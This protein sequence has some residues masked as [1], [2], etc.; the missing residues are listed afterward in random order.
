MLC[1]IGH[2]PTTTSFPINDI[3][4]MSSP[5]P[6]V[7]NLYITSFIALDIPAH[8]KSGL[9][10]HYET[11][12]PCRL[13]FEHCTYNILLSSAD[14]IPIWYLSHVESGLAVD[15]SIMMT[16]HTLCSYPNLDPFTSLSD[17]NFH[18]YFLCRVQTLTPLLHAMLPW[19]RRH[20]VYG[21]V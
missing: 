19:W 12:F 1:P 3:S 10:L 5:T 15:T 20:V 11:V 18:V 7:S 2:T 14:L 4:C 16:R 13:W 9:F 8:V 17:L 21:F 6:Q